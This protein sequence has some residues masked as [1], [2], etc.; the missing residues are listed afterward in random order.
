MTAHALRIEV[1]GQ[2]NGL[3]TLI[4]GVLMTILAFWTAGQLFLAWYHGRYHGAC[5]RPFHRPPERPK[6]RFT[7][8]L[9]PSR[10]GR[11]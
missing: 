7:S 2:E 10:G 1:L 5:A 6:A 9:S 3:L 4:S 11:I 8:G